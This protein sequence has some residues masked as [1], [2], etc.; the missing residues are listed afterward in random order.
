MT[1]LSKEIG[2]GRIK[3]YKEENIKTLHK[4]ENYC[5]NV[6][7]R[8]LYSLFKLSIFTRA[9]LSPLFLVGSMF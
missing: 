1:V 6:Y 8:T 2:G 7:D 5:L 3:K 9:Q 4:K